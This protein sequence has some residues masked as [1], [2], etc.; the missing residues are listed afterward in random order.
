MEP[1]GHQRPSPPS[2]RPAAS[3]EPSHAQERPDLNLDITSTTTLHLDPGDHHAAPGV[4]KL[5]RR[6]RVGAGLVDLFAVADAVAVGVGV[7]RVGRGVAVGAVVRAR[8][9]GAV[10]Q[11]VA[12]GVGGRR[13]CGVV[14]V[15]VVL[16]ARDLLLV[17]EAVA[18]G[19]GLVGV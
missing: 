6:P 14:V 2:H 1:G 13:V 8:D 16:G 18:V 5:V 10:A 11:A 17:G 12:V 15:A 4:R 9:L 3:R 19:V 7:Q